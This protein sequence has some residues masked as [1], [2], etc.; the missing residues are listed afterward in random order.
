MIAPDVIEMIDNSILH[1]EAE[2]NSKKQCF[3]I[4]WYI[5]TK[6]IAHTNKNINY[7]YAME[8]FCRPDRH[9]RCTL[10]V[11]LCDIPGT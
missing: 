10:N 2:I 9:G 5:L 4:L 11:D 3:Y 8:P 1:T 7:I 6:G